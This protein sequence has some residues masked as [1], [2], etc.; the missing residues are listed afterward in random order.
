MCLL[1]MERDGTKGRIFDIQRFCTGDGPGIRTTVFLKGCPLRCAWC[2]N[3]ESQDPCTEI[4]FNAAQCVFCG[5][6]AAVCPAGCHTFYA[7][8][9]LFDRKKCLRCGACADVCP[10]ALE[11]V[12]REI[13]AEEAAEEACKDKLFYGAAGGLT[14]S[15]GEPLMQ[16]AFTRALLKAAKE[17]GLHTCVETSGFAPFS[18]LEEILP[19][20]D[21]FL[22]DCK[23]SPARHRAF[24]GEES[25][26]ITENLKKLDGAGARIVL[27]CPLFPNLNDG[28]EHLKGVAALAET[29]GHAEA[30]E[31][32]PGHSVGAGKYERMGY[33]RRAPQFTPPDAEKIG[34]WIAYLSAR[35]SVPV[36]RA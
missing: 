36:R 29:L 6:C 7:G 17:R 32:E 28:E 19:Y 4:A 18:A 8:K 23:A 22:Y 27:R 34:E 30:I 20:T 3:P 12:G 5:A 2:H 21:L 25:A 1:D 24:T 26:R 9:H 16:P 31:I 14:V 10:A 33:A 11:R 13:G 15:G 35:T